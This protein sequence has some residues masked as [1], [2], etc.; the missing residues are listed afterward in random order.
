M[1]DFPKN[2][3]FLSDVTIR[4]SNPIVWLCN[5]LSHSILIVFKL[6]FYNIVWSLIIDVCV[7]LD[8]MNDMIDRF[9]NSMDYSKYILQYFGMICHPS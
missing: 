6:L 4:S 8:I 7:F 5:S 2:R 9:S 3:K 1:D